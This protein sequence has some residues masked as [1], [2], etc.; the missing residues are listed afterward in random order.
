MPNKFAIDAR[1]DES[2]LASSAPGTRLCAPRDRFP[3]ATKLTEAKGKLE[4]ID[5]LSGLISTSPKLAS[6]D[7]LSSDTVPQMPTTS[8][9]SNPIS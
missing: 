1:R 7:G 9:P 4:R 5:H 6:T 2:A 3:L 8:D